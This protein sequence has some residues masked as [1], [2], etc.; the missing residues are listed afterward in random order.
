MQKTILVTG[1]TG[2]IGKATALEIAKTKAKVVLLARNRQK[3]E[4]VKAE[5]TKQSGNNAIDILVAD[6]SD[7]ASVKN[8]AAQFKQNYD[9]LD[10][11]VNIAAVHRG[12]REVT[13][14][15]L[16]M[17]FATNHLGVFVLTN[18]LL[19]LL[20]ASKP[21][22]IVTVSAPST[23]KVNFDDL[24]SEKNF[25]GINRFFASK[26][27]NL[28]FTYDLADRLKGTGVTA[29][30][31]HPG[32]VKSEITNEMPGLLKFIFGVLSTGPDK[33][34]KALRNL[35]VSEKYEGVS[36][37]FFDFK[38]NERKSSDYSHDKAIQQKLWKVSEALSS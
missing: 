13:K 3:L 10:V 16:E 6:L 14:S 17:M 28:L 12:K 7:I 30:V 18:Q 37:K 35:A 23:T 29:T 36:G 31:F 21:S 26:M 8:A 27:M 25:A 9:R 32:A 20:K 2:A 4:A 33:A 22:R 5:L 15:G 34:A 11:L 38:E 19:E 24:Q 1:V